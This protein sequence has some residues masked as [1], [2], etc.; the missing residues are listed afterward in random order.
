ML[1]LTGRLVR[2]AAAAGR[3]VPGT[4]DSAGGPTATGPAAHLACRCAGK[5]PTVAHEP[6]PVWFDSCGQLV[7]LRCTACS[8]RAGLSRKHSIA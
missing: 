7:V 4:H 6:T 1:F 2:D 8:K 5:L 3:R